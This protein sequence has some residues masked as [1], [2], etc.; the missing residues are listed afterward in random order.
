MS[1]QYAIA[2]WASR[3]AYLRQ[4]TAKYLFLRTIDSGRLPAILT[5][6]SPNRSDGLIGNFSTHS[7]LPSELFLAQ[8]IYYF[9]VS[10]FQFVV[11]VFISDYWQYFGHRWMHSNKFMYSLSHPSP[12]SPFI[13]LTFASLGTL[14]TFILGIITSPSPTPMAPSTHTPSKASFRILSA[15]S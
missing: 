10:I 9:V 4:L 1:D 14:D 2:V 12:V 13:R 3:V 7:F 11:A 5:T 8:A 6:F 15:W